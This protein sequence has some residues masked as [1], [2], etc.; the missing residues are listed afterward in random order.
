MGPYHVGVEISCPSSFCH[1]TCMCSF[2]NPYI[3]MEL[4]FG[5]TGGSLHPDLSSLLNNLIAYDNGDLGRVLYMSIR[6][7]PYE[8]KGDPRIMPRT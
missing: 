3:D 7:P 1:Y 4:S 2:K 8:L 6:P 5:Q